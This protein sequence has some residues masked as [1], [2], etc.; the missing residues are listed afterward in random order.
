M[1][2][3]LIL[4]AGGTLTPGA[5]RAIAEQLQRLV[6]SGRYHTITIRLPPA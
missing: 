6:A 2:P 1:K 3:L 4:V 5:E